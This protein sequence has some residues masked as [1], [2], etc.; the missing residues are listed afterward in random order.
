[1][2]SSVAVRSGLKTVWAMRAPTRCAK[3]QSRKENSVAKHAG[4]TFAFYYSTG[5]A[6]PDPASGYSTYEYD[7]YCTTNAQ[8]ALHDSYLNLA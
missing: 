2:P 3:R 8:P 4:N 5:T 6:H 7:E 1:M